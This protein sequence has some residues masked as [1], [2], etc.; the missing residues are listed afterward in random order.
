[1]NSWLKKEREK[2]LKE[3]DNELEY[4]GS[5]SSGYLVFKCDNHHIDNNIV[6][7]SSDSEIS[8]N[9]LLQ[10]QMDFTMWFK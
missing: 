9:D 3:V 5:Y 7:V 1:M 2:M 4:H 6:Y 10:A 8:M